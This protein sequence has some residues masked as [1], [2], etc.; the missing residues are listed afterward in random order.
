MS[1]VPDDLEG[2]DAFYAR[3]RPWLVATLR[4]IVGREAEDVAQDAMLELFRR[5]DSVARYDVP[6]AWV[7]RVAIRMAIRRR[8]R[9]VGRWKAET[10]AAGGGASTRPEPDATPL[11]SVLCI[12]PQADREALALRHVADRP[13]GEV[14]ERLGLSE[15]ATRVR[16][17]RARRRAAEGMAGLRGTWV[18]ETTWRR[19]SLADG[20][21]ANGFADAVEP[22]LDN[23]AECGP[24]RT[25][26]RL[27]GGRFL[28]TNRD[29]VHLDHGRYR[30]DGRRLT[31]D[32]TGY[33]GGVTYATTMDGNLMTLRQIDNRNPVVHGVPDAAFQF[34]LLG[35]STFRW[36]PSK[37]TP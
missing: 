6:E 37:S 33:P 9:E 28:M 18:M 17:L 31:L 12:L 24:I 16:L 22:V 25:V 10:L 26:L 21:R 32:S 34:A 36:E 20:L 2:F 27:D 8:T 35:S 1:S 29:D 13:I 15:S 19:G 30:F 23:L 4:P 3:R 7:R 5:W 11:G 14:A